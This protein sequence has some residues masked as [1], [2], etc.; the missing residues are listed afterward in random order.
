MKVSR[1]EDQMWHFSGPEHCGWAQ[2]FVE[3]DEFEETI[4]IS[5]LSEV[6]DFCSM[7]QERRE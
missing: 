1:K 2:T 5:S 3:R 4:E 7:C 6:S